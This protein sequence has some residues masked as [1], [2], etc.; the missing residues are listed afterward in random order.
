MGH[1]GGGGRLELIRSS[2]FVRV[3]CDVVQVDDAPAAAA[4]CEYIMAFAIRGFIELDRSPESCHV[5]QC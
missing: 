3:L 2:A 4:Q 5:V 1:S